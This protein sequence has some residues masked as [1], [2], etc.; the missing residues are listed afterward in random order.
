MQTH[1]CEIIAMISFIHR[2]GLLAALVLMLGVIPAAGQGNDIIWVRSS[3]TAGVNSIRFSKSGVYIAIGDSAGRLSLYTTDSGT[4]VRSFYANSTPIS[5]IRFSPRDT[6]LVATAGINGMVMEWNVFTGSKAGEFVGTPTA[7]ATAI[8]Y[9]PESLYLASGHAQPET[10]IR[11]WKTATHDIAFTVPGD[12][13]RTRAIAFSGR[14]TYLA[15]VGE[16]PGVAVHSIG[17]SKTLRISMPT[18]G[19]AVA[20]SSAGAYLAAAGDDGNIYLW[21]SP[22]GI[23][24]GPGSAPTLMRLEG[25]TGPVTDVAFL[26]GG[27]YM[28]SSGRDSTVRVWN[29]STGVNIYTYR[30]YPSQQ[31]CV[32]VSGEI[33]VAGAADGSVI[34]RHLRLGDFQQLSAPVLLSPKAYSVNQSREPLLLWGAV[35][36]ATHYEVQLGTDSTMASGFV[37]NGA[38]TPDTSMQIA[39]LAATTAYYW[40]VRAVGDGSLSPWAMVSMFVTGTGGP[41]APVLIEP[42]NN[43]GKH[44]TTLNFRW[45]ASP[46]ATTYRLQVSSYDTLFVTDVARDL[47]VSDTSVMVS[48]LDPYANYYWRVRAENQIG[49][50]IWSPVWLFGTTE[51]AGEVDRTADD[52]PDADMR[53]APNPARGRTAIQLTLPAKQTT[54]RL[55]LHDMCGVLRATLFENYHAGEKNTVFFDASTLSAGVYYLSLEYNGCVR[56][57][58]IVVQQ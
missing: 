19:N 17:T 5:T 21:N 1:A 13:T 44:P 8:D 53:V 28:V 54:V 46:A 35:E 33:I 20:F 18:A 40:R 38:T 27:T 45:H 4:T 11:V 12:P 32:A 9:A 50:G 22:S 36:G 2:A 34:L 41:V 14:E 29:T 16:T 47:V 7:S 58:M 56:R 15:V 42:A 6:Q 31:L 26:P 39:Q 48:G 52:T 49:A 55:R 37:V 10:K 24:W 3:G 23:G 30:D 25:H 57:T 51:I 43:T